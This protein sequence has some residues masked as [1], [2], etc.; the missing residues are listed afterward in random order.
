LKLTVRGRDV[1]RN[2]MWYALVAK[3]PQVDEAIAWFAT[4]S[5]KTKGAKSYTAKLLPAWAYVLGQHSIPLAVDALETYARE[6]GL[7]L[8]GKTFRMYQEYCAAAGRSAGIAA[9]PAPPPPPSMAELMLQAT[10]KAMSVMGMAARVEN[11]VMR[12]KGQLDE[13]LISISDGAITRVS[14]GRHVRLEIDMSQGPYRHFRA[15]LDGPDIQGQPNM[16]RVMACA[17]I[18]Q[19]D[20]S[21]RDKIVV[22]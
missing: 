8:E 6:G 2:L 7:Q 14:D 3:D 22:E 10:G 17:R 16:F 15:A 11:G 9:Q 18:L 1:L 21:E 4:A 19:N 13:Y 12:V 20:A 5:W